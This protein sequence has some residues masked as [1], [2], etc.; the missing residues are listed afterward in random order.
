MSASKNA[1]R[2]AREARERLR[3]YNARQSVHNLQVSR[4]RRDNII[5]IVGVVVIAALATLTQVFYFTAGPGMPTPS[6]SPS[7][8]SSPAAGKNVGDV[9]AKTIAENRTWTGE[10]TLNDAKLGISLDGA[11]APQ[12]TSVFIDLAKKNFYTTTGA[13][14]HRLTNGDS[15]KLIQC[16]SVDGKGAGDVGFSFGPL[17][18]VPTDG[19]YPAGTIAMARGDSAYS[20]SSQFFITYADTNLPSTTGGYTIF[21]KVTSGL[22]EFVSGIADAGVTP[23]ASGTIDGAPVVPTKITQLTVQ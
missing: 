8:S 6:A 7:P 19:V 15:F 12:A 17:E 21:G 13:T 4:R 18:N 16:G 23:S 14:C 2:D 3:R 22:P 5:A 1:E 9:P 11:N 20:Q 10:L